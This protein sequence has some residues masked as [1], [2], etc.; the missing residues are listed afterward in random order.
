MV[1]DS[2]NKSGV[3]RKARVFPEWLQSE[4]L[5]RSEFWFVFSVTASSW[6]LQNS[7]EQIWFSNQNSG[8]RI[9]KYKISTALPFLF[10]RFCSVWDFGASQT[11]N[12]TH[13]TCQWKE[14]IMVWCTGNDLVCIMVFST[15]YTNAFF[16]FTP[17]SYTTL[18]V[19]SWGWNHAMNLLKQF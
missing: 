10:H 13:K 4:P 15:T 17:D 3:L 16:L 7:K 9:A 12:R 2:G 1:R 11:L 14:L 6:K 5:L 18:S 8:Y 19:L